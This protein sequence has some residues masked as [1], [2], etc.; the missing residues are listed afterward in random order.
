MGKRRKLK[1]SV[2]ILF[3]AESKNRSQKPKSKL[4]SQKQ[5]NISLVRT[6]A[7]SGCKWVFNRSHCLLEENCPIIQEEWRGYS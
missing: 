1:P 2:A 7:T 6:M 5:S 3:Y 4:K